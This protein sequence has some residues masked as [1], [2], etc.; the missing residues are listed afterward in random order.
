[1]R[2]TL[3]VL[4]GCLTAAGSAQIL[5]DSFYDFGGSQGLNGWT[6]RYYD[7]TADVTPGYDFLSDA[8]LMP[9]FNSSDNKWYVQKGTYWTMLGQGSAHG[10][11]VITSGGRSPAD[12]IAIKRWTSSYTGRVKISTSV[13]KINTNGGNGV[14]ASLFVN[15]V[16]FGSQPIA[17]NDLTGASFDV[18]TT[19]TTG[20]AIEWWLDPSEGNDL[21]DLSRLEG[22]VTAVPEPK[23][24]AALAIGVAAML[25]R[26]RR[27]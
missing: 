10:N 17:Y 19:L 3:V 1:M 24:L 8:W 18:E 5:A 15:G 22:S 7:R 12:H 20:D 4:T 13:G 25:G 6:Y 27:S 26:R 23:V 9:Q 21:F 16:S 2:F 14:I 11:G